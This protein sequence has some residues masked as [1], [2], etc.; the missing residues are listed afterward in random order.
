MPGFV[1]PEGSP[2]LHYIAFLVWFRHPSS[3][4]TFERYFGAFLYSCGAAFPLTGSAGV[5]LGQTVAVVVN[6]GRIP[7]QGVHRT[8]VAVEREHSFSVANQAFPR[9]AVH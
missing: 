5:V 7:N 4:G 8:V 3:V 1:P 9:T 2:N 6:S